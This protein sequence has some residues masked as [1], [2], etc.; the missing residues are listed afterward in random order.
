MAFKYIPLLWS[1]KGVIMDN[2]GDTAF[3]PELKT[4]SPGHV[5][6]TASFAR[7]KKKKQTITTTKK[8]ISPN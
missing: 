1:E 2:V 3:L 6:D 5:S 8:H 7:A 4:I